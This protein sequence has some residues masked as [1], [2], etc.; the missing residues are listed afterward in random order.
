M[1]LGENS[2]FTV[3]ANQLNNP[4]EEDSLKDSIL[5]CLISDYDSK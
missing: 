3:I 4:D 1:K 2:E 5:P